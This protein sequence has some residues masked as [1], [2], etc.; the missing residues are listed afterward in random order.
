MPE[1]PEV[2]TTKRGIEPYILGQKISQ[3]IVRERRLRWT[4]PDELD[5][6]A[7]EQTIQ[8][9]TRRAK[10]L[11]IKLPSGT[12]LIHLGMSGS[13]RIV[14]INTPINKHDHLDI[15][16]A[17]GSVLRYHDPRRFGCILW[18]Q[19]PV[20]HKLLTHLGPEPLT[21]DFNAEYLHKLSVNRTLAI[22]LFI[23]DNKTVVGIGNIYANEALF[24]AGINPNKPANTISKTRYQ[25]LVNSIK[26]VLA[27]AIKAGG[28]TLRDFVGGDGYPGYFQQ[29]LNVYGRG[30]LP[31]KCCDRMLKETKL[32]QRTTVW[33]SHCQK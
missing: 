1:L 17:N 6:L 28:T 16:L 23:M 18:T 10:Y 4:I 15:L 32:G 14:D 8:A 11:L 21:D 3:V 24:A 19:D 12:I 31:C 5:V 26:E 29:T 22:K 27:R 30:Q 33:C 25:R 13:L 9:I 7:S 2:E 20:S